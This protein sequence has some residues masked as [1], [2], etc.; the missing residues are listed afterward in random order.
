MIKDLVT[1]SVEGFQE[2]LSDEEDLGN[3][4]TYRGQARRFGVLRTGYSLSDEE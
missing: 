4:M 2:E 3:M 1:H